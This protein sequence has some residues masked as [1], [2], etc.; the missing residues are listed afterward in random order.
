MCGILGICFD[1]RERTDAEWM[2]IAWD[3][4]NLWIQSMQRGTD[5]AGVYIVNRDSEIQ[6]IKAPVTSES[7]VDT[8]TSR[9]P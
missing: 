2:D 4:S 7:I 6:Y 9:H 5:A 3:F 8:N 1:G